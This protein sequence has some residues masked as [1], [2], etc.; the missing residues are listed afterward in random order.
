MKLNSLLRLKY[1]AHKNMCQLWQ[2][3]MMKASRTQSAF[4]QRCAR[5]NLVFAEAVRG[6]ANDQR[7]QNGDERGDGG[8]DARMRF[9]EADLSHMQRQEEHEARQPCKHTNMLKSASYIGGE[10]QKGVVSPAGY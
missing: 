9:V 4:Q 5:T 8:D 6:R 2:H 7:A 10:Q 3:A 1:A